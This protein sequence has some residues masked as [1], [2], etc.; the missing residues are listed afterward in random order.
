MFSLLKMENG[1]ILGKGTCSRDAYSVAVNSDGKIVYTDRI[2]LEN[3]D[4][5]TKEIFIEIYEQWDGEGALDMYTTRIHLDIES[6]RNNKNKV[7]LTQSYASKEQQVSFKYPANWE[8]SGEDN[9]LHIIGPEDIDGKSAQMTFSIYNG[10]QSVEEIVEQKR[11]EANQAKYGFGTSKL[12]IGGV[13]GTYY[14]IDTGNTKEGRILVEKE[15]VVHDIQYTAI[16]TQYERNKLVIQKILES[17]EW[18]APEKS[19]KTFANYNVMLKLYEDNTLGFIANEDYIQMMNEYIKNPCV[20]EKNTEYQVNGIQDNITNIWI[21]SNDHPT[22]FILTE[23]EELYY[24]NTHIGLETG[25]FSIQKIEGLT[26]VK[27]VS[28]LSCSF[29]EIECNEYKI[30]NG[31]SQWT[32]Y[33]YLLDIYSGV[34]DSI[35]PADE[36]GGSRHLYNIPTTGPSWTEDIPSTGPSIDLSFPNWNTNDEPNFQTDSEQN[37]R[38]PIVKLNTASYDTIQQYE[39]FGVTISFNS[40]ASQ[41]TEL[42]E[43]GIKTD[44]TT[45]RIYGLDW[46]IE[47]IYRIE[48]P[49]GFPAYVFVMNEGEYK[50]IV[51]INLDAF[52]GYAFSGGY[53][54]DPV[55]SIKTDNFYNFNVRDIGGEYWRLLYDRC[56]YIDSG[57][58]QAIKES[59]ASG[60]TRIPNDV[61]FITYTDDLPDGLY[62]SPDGRIIDIENMIVMTNSGASYGCNARLKYD[63][64]N[65]KWIVLNFTITVD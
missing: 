44:G 18:V 8:V 53:C 14:Q 42:Q 33:N 19:Y 27:K 15:G 40:G 45:Y 36:V 2:L 55:G 34:I 58:A 39:D 38:V 56:E 50:R 47:N 4:K 1:N 13:E 65:N 20:I 21:E 62:L 28:A 32:C 24:I 63:G 22:I 57:I 12:S 6:A 3:V 51:V 7:D 29:G 10:E 17:I 26:G 25:T 48:T 54:V 52:D 31:T 41:Y 61:D 30:Y 49:G 43:H 60:K 35:F 37:R 11:S 16:S 9:I 46:A 5:D 23:K 64:T 59:I